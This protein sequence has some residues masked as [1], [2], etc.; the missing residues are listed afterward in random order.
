M[1]FLIKT[2]TKKWFTYVTIQIKKECTFESI[3]LID[4]RVDLNYIFEGLILSK[5]FSKTFQILNMMNESKLVVNYKLCDAR[6]YKRGICLEGLFILVKN[7]TQKVILGFI[8]LNIMHP[9]KIDES[10]LE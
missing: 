7:C 8:V 2:I 3:A 6:V 5:Y 9:I 1:Q 10:R 4:S